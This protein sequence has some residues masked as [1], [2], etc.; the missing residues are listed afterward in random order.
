MP[1]FTKSKQEFSHGGR[2]IQRDLVGGC[3]QKGGSA[4][5]FPSVVSSPSPHSA[6]LCSKY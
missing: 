6:I 2:I 5:Y 4:K 1:A 3:R